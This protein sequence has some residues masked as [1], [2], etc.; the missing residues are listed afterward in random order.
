MGMTDEE[1]RA[2]DQ[3]CNSSEYAQGLLGYARWVFQLVFQS[4]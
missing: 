4:K 2:S 3:L 1:Y